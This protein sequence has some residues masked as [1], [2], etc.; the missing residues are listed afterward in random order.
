VFS[1]TLLAIVSL[2]CIPGILLMS[3]G[4]VRMELTHLN[5]GSTYISARKLWW[6]SV[7]QHLIIVLIFAAIGTLLGKRVGLIDSFLAQ[8]AGGGGWDSSQLILQLIAGIIGGVFCTV[9]WIAA[10]YLFFRKRIDKKT[11][12]VSEQIRLDLGLWTRIMSGGFVEEVIFRWGI[13][14]LSVWLI[15]FIPGI[16]VPTAIWSSLFITGIVFGLIHIPGYVAKGCILTPFLFVSMVGGNLWVALFCGWLF[17]QYGLIAAIIVHVLFHLLWYPFDLL[18][19]RRE[20][21]KV[22]T[23]TPS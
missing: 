1:W 16:D 22:T 5:E 12:Q 18:Y 2:L 3:S 6:L 20:S 8:L 15:L 13:L 4:V 14:S 19:S 7:I 21:D 23:A 10:Y 11:I 9:V 17:W